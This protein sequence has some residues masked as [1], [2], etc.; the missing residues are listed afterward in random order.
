VK[1]KKCVNCGTP[2]HLELYIN[3]FYRKETI[4]L[5]YPCSR[6]TFAEYTNKEFMKPWWEKEGNDLKNKSQSP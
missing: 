1:E 3:P 2:E 6:L 4:Y 5:C